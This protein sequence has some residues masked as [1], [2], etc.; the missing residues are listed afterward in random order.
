[1]SSDAFILPQWGGIVLFNLPADSPA[2]L[3]LSACDLDHAFSVFRAQLL[4]L[5]GVPALP[6][7]VVSGDPSSPLTQWQLDTLYRRRAIENVVSSKETLESIAKLVSQIPNMPVGQ[8]VRGDIQD[9][10]AALEKVRLTDR[11]RTS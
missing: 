6:S 5:L 10:L 1:M 2:R 9:S 8:D 3:H 11:L 7:G 4:T